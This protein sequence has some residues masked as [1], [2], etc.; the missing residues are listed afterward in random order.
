MYLPHITKADRHSSYVSGGYILIVLTNCV[1]GGMVQYT[2]VVIVYQPTTQSKRDL[3]P[4]MAVASEVNQMH[5]PG[6]DCSHFL[7]VFD[8]GSHLNM[9][10]SDAWADL[11]R[12]VER[13]LEIAVERLALPHAPM[14]L[15]D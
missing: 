2:H 11:D 15:P 4:I 7:G 14:L 6:D 3:Q 9:G 12:F 5:Q 13:A 8:G 10:C 1:S